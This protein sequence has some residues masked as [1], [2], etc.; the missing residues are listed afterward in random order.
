MGKISYPKLV[1]KKQWLY[2]RE[3]F[4][5]DGRRV[6][7]LTALGRAD[8]PTW[9]QR[10]EKIR[11]RSAAVS[12][13]VVPGSLEA[14]IIEYRSALP[15]RKTKKG[16]PLSPVT[17]KNYA[18]DLDLLV[19]H[20]GRAPVRII[21]A[22]DII[23]MQDAFADR[24]GVANNMIARLRA[25]LEFGRLRGWIHDNPAV[26]IPP[27][28]LSEHAPWPAEVLQAALA[29]ASPMMALAI[30]TG[31]C[32]GWRD[33]DIIRIQHSWIAHNICTVER[34]SKTKVSAS[35]P[36]HP[37]WAEAIASIPR[38]ADTLLYDRAGQP[39]TSPEPIQA[40]M[41]RIMST[42]EVREAIRV[43]AGRGECSETDRF[44]F[45]GL[46]KNACCYL[47][48]LGLN[49]SQV[50]GMLG[51][52]AEMVRYYSRRRRSLMLARS[53]FDTVLSGNVAGLWRGPE[54]TQLSNG[55]NS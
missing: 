46:R 6:E 43:A 36:V 42:A 50:G 16:Q 1:Q 5:M 13:G 19:Q 40:A 33:G 9:I 39:F 15:G 14:L 47:T 20:F 41:R 38:R 44:V 2:Y 24:P 34:Q 49:D 48:E 26:R 7:R 18:R 11:A 12:V 31:L 30:S 35:V 45:H 17:L 23:E 4:R 3:Q 28:A 27:L 10:Y 51:M 25:V 53:G 32:T 21:R 29:V 52:S 55:G 22:P 8:D 37:M 54:G